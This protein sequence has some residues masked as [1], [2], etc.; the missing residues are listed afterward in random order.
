MAERNFAKVRA[1]CSPVSERQRPARSFRAPQ[2]AGQTKNS[3]CLSHF[4]GRAL[5]HLSNPGVDYCPF[6]FTLRDRPLATGLRGQQCRI[7]LLHE[8]RSCKKDM[9]DTDDV[10]VICRDI[11]HA[12]AWVTNSI[13]ITSL[14]ENEPHTT[15]RHACLIHVYFVRAVD[16]YDSAW[17]NSER[18]ECVHRYRDTQC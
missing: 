3:G 2:L 6:G 16:Y 7:V 10:A 13:Q 18:E 1:N 12:N 4:L 5:R 11:K 14:Q 8:W 9:S 15:T 17:C